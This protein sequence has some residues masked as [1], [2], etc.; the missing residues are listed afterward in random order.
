MKYKASHILN[1]ISNPYKGESKDE[2]EKICEKYGE[3]DKSKLTKEDKEGN[4][5]R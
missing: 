5:D 4:D 3:K 2:W 1:E